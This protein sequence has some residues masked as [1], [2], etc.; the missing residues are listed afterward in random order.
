MKSSSNLFES[1]RRFVDWFPASDLH[2]RETYLAT[3]NEKVWTFQFTES[4][5][6]SKGNQ[7]HTNIIAQ[8]KLRSSKRWRKRR[9]SGWMRRSTEPR[10]NYFTVYGKKEEKAKIAAGEARRCH[11][12]IFENIA[13]SITSNVYWKK[14]TDK[15]IK[16]YKM[17]KLLVY[18]YKTEFIIIQ[19]FSLLAY[20]CST[21]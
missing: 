18:I 20:I 13:S 4:R 16:I 1:C 5:N 11:N 7:R 8:L 12:K 10:G 14:R 19:L 15:T 3:A 21:Q 9:Y 2:L 6:L 17:H